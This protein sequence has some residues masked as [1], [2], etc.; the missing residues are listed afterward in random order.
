M[1][2]LAAWKLCVLSKVSYIAIRKASVLFRVPNVDLITKIVSNL[3]SK[4]AVVC[5]ELKNL[6]NLMSVAVGNYIT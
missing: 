6:Q 2:H 4:L 3:S 1:C 5:E